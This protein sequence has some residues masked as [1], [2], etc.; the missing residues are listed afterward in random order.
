V[1]LSI[2]SPTILRVPRADYSDDTILVKA[3]CTRDVDA[4]AYL[5]DRYHAPLV[6]IACIYVPNREVAEEAVQETWLAVVQGIDRFEQR[7]SLKTWLYRILINI[8]RARGVKEQRSIPYAAGALLDEERSV[9]PHRFRRFGRYKGGWKTPPESW[10]E[11]EQRALDAEMLATI[12]SAA[13][14]L[15]PAQREVLT[16]RDILGWNSAEVCDALDVSEGNQRVL[17]HRARS[18]IRMALE[19]Y[20]GKEGA[21]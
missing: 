18:K 1:N 16:L 7:S 19:H 14:R 8:A 9:D 10:P 20:Y 5:V 3:L 15:P 21:Q 4:F 6:R 2:P 11:P 17:L 13:E 12:Q